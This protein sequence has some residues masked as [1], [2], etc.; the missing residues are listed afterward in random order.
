[1]EKIRDMLRKIMGGTNSIVVGVDLIKRA[2][3][4]TGH[5][6]EDESY[7]LFGT[8]TKDKQAIADV[9]SW[10]AGY[11]SGVTDTRQVQP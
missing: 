5:T 11:L 9:T 8:W 7:L 3:S 2:L 6:F 10:M 4:D 1:M